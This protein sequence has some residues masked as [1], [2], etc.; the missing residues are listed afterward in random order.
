MGNIVAAEADKMI[1]ALVGNATYTA[2]AA[3]YV[4]LHIGDPG[5]AGTGNPAAT[6]TRMAATMAASSGGAS[7]NSALVE[8]TSL[9]NAETLTHVSFWTAVTGGSFLG[10]DQLSSPAAVGVG[11]TFRIPAGDL[12]VTI[13][14]VL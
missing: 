11:D 1:Q 3:F 4:K 10:N 12:D 8:W 9:A 5:A 7:T 14:T 13:T 2:S 6:T